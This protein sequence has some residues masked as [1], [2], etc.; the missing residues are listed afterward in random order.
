[1][2]KY[3]GPIVITGMGAVSPFGSGVKALWSALERGERRSMI[4][5]LGEPPV[6]GLAVGEWNPADLLGKR[7]LQYLRPSSQ[8]LLGASLLALQEA[9]LASGDLPPDELGIVVG[10]NLGGAQSFSDYDYTAITEG[11]H[12]TSPMEAP[13]T[14][15][16]APASHLAIRLK[17][18]ALNTTIASGQC[19]G[20]DALGYAMKMLRNG[21]AQQTVVGGVEE[22]SSI[23][24]STYRDA[25]VVVGGQKEDAGLPFDEESTGWLPSEGAAV[26]MLERQ[27]DAVARGA[28]PLAELA[29]WS[30][31]FA[32]SQTLEKR[33][34]VLRRTAEQALDAA[35]LSPADVDVVVAGANGLRMG[36]QAEALA[37]QDLFAHQPQVF[38]SAIK[39]ILGETYGA[40]GLFQALAAVCM[41]DYGMVPLTVTRERQHRLTPPVSG[42]SAETRPWVG[43]KCGTILLLTQDLFGSTSAVVIRG[44]ER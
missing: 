21:R 19:A 16:N 43:S 42:L 44:C 34:S 18:R 12:T 41:I 14:L 17:A 29:G 37:L 31:A 3:D 15:A 26:V 39:G 5:R 40:S 7:G 23:A 30:S 33:S 11:P 1:M 6:W 27:A 20:L 35:H 13:N 24:L 36:D 28:R 4:V 9:G 25:R 8:F 22:L 2:T 10:C 32:P 38:V